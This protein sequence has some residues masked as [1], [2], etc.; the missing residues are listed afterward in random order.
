MVT[1][2]LI[3]MCPRLSPPGATHA[4]LAK[5]GARPRG[6]GGSGDGGGAGGDAVLV[7]A[8]AAAAARVAVARVVAPDA[9]PG[10]PSGHGR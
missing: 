3:Y 4:C 6:E 5:A 10:R 7:M 8:T 9:A 2:P 1:V